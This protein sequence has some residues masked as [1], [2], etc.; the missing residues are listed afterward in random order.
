DQEPDHRT[1][2]FI[3]SGRSGAAKHKSTLRGTPKG[4]IMS[5]SERA[6]LNPGIRKTIGILLRQF[7]EHFRSQGTPGRLTDIVT[8]QRP[9]ERDSDDSSAPLSSD[10]RTDR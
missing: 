3:P 9:P 2:R 6:R 8:R 1:R 7:Y 10:R 5:V 4:A